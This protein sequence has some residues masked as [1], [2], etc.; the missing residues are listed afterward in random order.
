MNRTGW[1][2][3]ALA[4]A[5]WTAGC[6]STT[7]EQRRA[8]DASAFRDRLGRETREVRARLDG[9]LALSNCLALAHERN[10]G[11]LNRR[12]DEQLAG[13]R[14]AAAF[15]A[16]LPQVT[17]SLQTMDASDPFEKRMGGNVVQ[18]QDSA[19]SEQ[20]LSIVL[21]IFTPDT[22]L[23]YVAA[24]RG[25]DAQARVRQAAEHALDLQVLASFARCVVADETRRA[26]DRRVGFAERLLADSRA[27]EREGFARPADVAGVRASLEDARKRAGD[28]ARDRETAAMA[29]CQLMAIEPDPGL[30]IDADSL[31]GLRPGGV[32]APGA[33]AVLAS[34]PETWGAEALTRRPDLYAADEAVRL[35]KA[36]IARA[37]AMFLPRLAGFATYSTTTDDFTVNQGTW[38]TGMQGTMSVFLGFR[39][40]QEYRMARVAAEQTM[41]T[42]EESALAVLVQVSDAW[43][44]VR[45]AR[46]TERSA[47]AALEAAA[48][49]RATVEA[50]HAEGLA[51]VAERLEAQASTAAAEAQLAAARCGLAAVLHV[52][53]V[54]LGHPLHP[55]A[56]KES[57]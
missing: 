17:Y 50:R 54:A 15:S 11:L 5:G 37:I 7:P 14:R 48:A 16:F 20:Q 10:L 30:A 6:R 55:V 34:P 28:A 49:D 13:V 51:P 25:E 8:D 56:G 12:L 35:R 2:A 42:R 57:P 36:E 47:A 27:L 43:R 26:W 31:A 29:L 52:F 39:T 21:P 45:G 22:W 33:D 19:V 3:A 24:R 9:P 40:I 4:V 32:P 44:L 18:V 23:M 38:L 1:L 53:H 46:D 41:R